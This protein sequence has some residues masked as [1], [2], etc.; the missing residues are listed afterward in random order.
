MHQLSDHLKDPVE[1][2]EGSTVPGGLDPHE[3]VGHGQRTQEQHQQQQHQVEVCR[4]KT[5]TTLTTTAL[6]D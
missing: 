4:T 3:G 2:T 6:V 5:R 1:L